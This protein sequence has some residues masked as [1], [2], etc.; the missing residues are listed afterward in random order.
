MKLSLPDVLIYASNE[1][2]KIIRLIKII[3]D[4]VPVGVRVVKE[5]A[6]FRRAG[7]EHAVTG[8]GE[9]LPLLA[10]KI[11]GKIFLSTGRGGHV[12]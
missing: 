7:R 4:S 6:C 9:G 8:V 3:N 2:M 10:R 12:K 1:K 5:V 11:L